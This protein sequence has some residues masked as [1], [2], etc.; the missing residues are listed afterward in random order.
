MKKEFPESSYTQNSDKKNHNRFSGVRSLKIMLIIV[1]AFFAYGLFAQPVISSFSPQSGPVN[2]TVT[3]TGSGFSLAPSLNVVFFGAYK[4]FVSASTNTSLT[5]SAPTGSNYQ[6]ISVTNVE[7]G[8]TGYSA[9]PFNITFP[10]GCKP[11][12]AAKVD[13]T[14]GT[15]P[16]SAGFCDM[17]NNGKPDLAVTNFGSNTVSVYYNISVPGTINAGSFAA[18]VD[19]ATGSSPKSVS[20]GDI[21]GDGRQD[22]I[23]TNSGDTSVSVFRNTS[24]FG[25]VS[26]A[27]RVNFPS[28]GSPWSVSISDIDG[29][30]KPDLV[31]ANRVSWTISVIRNTS[32]SG[33]ISFAPK[34]D[35][36]TGSS[37]YSVSIGDLDGDGKPDMAVASS[38]VSVFRNTSTSG[39]V[40]FAAR[41][42]FSAG[43]SPISVS[44]GDI[45][46]DGKLDMAVA[47][48]GS[49][50]ASVF[51]NTSTPGII[52]A[53]SFA[54]KVDFAAGGAPQTVSLGDIDGDGKP[55]MAVANF[56]SNSVSVLRNSSVSGTVNFSA[57]VDLSTAGQASYVNICDIDGDGKPDVAAT[58]YNSISMSVFR[59]LSVPSVLQTSASGNTNPITNGSITP[60]A[61]NFTDFGNLNLLGNLIRTYSFQNTSSDSLSVDSIKMSGADAASFSPGSI[62]PAGKIA[63]GASKTFTVTYVLSSLGIKNATVNIYSNINSGTVC[64]VQQTYTFAVKANQISLAPVITT[65]SPQSGPA[66]TNVNISG[67]GFNSTPSNNIVFF[68]AAL[69]TVSA[70]TDTSLTVSAP[71]GANYKYI[72]VTN[73][74]SNLTGYSSIPF[75][76]TFPGGCKTEFAARVNFSNGTNPYSI[77]IGDLDGDGKSDLAVA[78]YGS[79]TVSVL[80]NTSTTGG[81][82]FAAKVDF[83]TGFSPK[84]VNIGEI[85]GD[86]KPDLIVTNSTSNT[87]SVFRNTSTPGVINTGSFAAK[88]DFG[89]GSSPWFVS[90]GDLN[91]DGKS[92][93]AVVN[94]VSQT[95]SV[96]RNTSTSGGVSFAAKVDFGTGP[97]PY[98]VS[99]GDLDGD[100]KPDIAVANNG[101]NT[102]SVYQNTSTNGGVSF[103]A[104]VDFSAGSGPLSVSIG[105]I[106]GDGKQDLAVANNSGNNASVFRNTSTPGIINAGSFA[107]RVDFSAGG[108]PQIV[109][110]GDI[111]GDGKPDLTVANFTG[112]SVSV[113]R[114]TSVTGTISFSA[115]VDLSSAGQASSVNVGDIDG[116]GK[117]EIAATNYNGSSVSVFRNLVLPS[118]LQTAASGNGNPITNGSVTP[119][120]TNFTDFGNVSMVGSLNRTYTFQNS[121]TDSLSVDSIKMSGTDNALFTPG[122]ITPAGKIAPGGS[123]TFTVT[124]TPLTSGVKSATVMVY[125]NIN[126]GTACLLQQTYSF[127]V[128][129]TGFASVQTN[130]LNFDGTNDNVALPNALTTAFTGASTTEFTIEYW[131]KGT[132][133]QSAVRIQNGSGYIVAGWGSKHI[134]SSDGGTGGGVNVGAGATDGNWHHIAVTWKKN[135]TNGFRSYL[136]GALV[137]QINSSN[138]NL[139]VITSGGYLGAYNG[140]SE[141]MNGTLDEVRIWNRELSQ[142][143]IS[144]N[145]F[146]QISSGTGL[147]ASYH[148]NQGIAGGNNTGITTLT[149]ASPNNYTGT[150]NNFALNGPA[151]NFVGSG[152]GLIPTATTINITVLPEGFYNGG[153]DKL[154]LKDTLKA[155]LQSNVSP[156]SVID[157]AVAVIDSVTFTGS[158]IFANAPGGT[159]YIRVNH[160]NSLETWSKTGGEPLVQGTTMSYDFSSAAAQAFGNNMKQV[161]AAPVRYGIY[162]GDV[163]QDG[164][165][166]LND[167]LSV[168]NAAAVFSSG[169]GVNDINGDSI[170]DLN[171]ILIAYNNS[172]GFV[173]LIRP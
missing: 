73:L 33:A 61:T 46:G 14:S 22:M 63:P 79:N 148:F 137:Q 96:F 110:I 157:S 19:Y 118:S 37:T 112:I 83:A 122:S 160:R 92:D 6:Y 8:L 113:L 21:D 41:V 172:A 7:T 70:S 11:E 16:Y 71:T 132:S 171:D 66:G 45:D 144:T 107:S 121:S 78:N 155:Y 152:P 77:S 49:N 20:F 2:T 99:I 135:T 101:D 97:S 62:T 5:V 95:V 81:V 17:D 129:G 98:S 138:V 58:N 170:V 88:V 128:S 111:D 108:A 80:R 94:R 125:S 53:G 76:L 72:S 165:I 36:A 106:D 29:D 64:L 156:F 27:A 142:T 103:A 140:A 56:T 117:P 1:F 60:S 145:R 168:Y 93:L 67:S 40:S 126:S 146:L 32:T 141:F 18:K 161:N 166:D 173:S 42:D 10:G 68:G 57:K 13:Y 31:V 9:N 120:L 167:V 82:S 90:V 52:N 65:F 143:E 154:N 153:T 51:R 50:N 100:G 123:K 25:N 164:T 116:D 104:R 55:D 69:A 15:N 139:P 48:N 109:S 86:G 39:T 159:Y 91:G 4:V 43:S 105:D 149:D 162:S 30:G 150:L 12:F 131:F 169:Y 23:V 115:K 34:V 74:G 147:L 158:F 54:A 59:N 84:S 89:T 85:D 114:N 102:A 87:V 127:A 151:S 134:I 130:V 3:I 38:T 75:N 35:F 24:T 26:F 47:N 133:V 163:N 28:G 124:F 119:S 44:I 136:D